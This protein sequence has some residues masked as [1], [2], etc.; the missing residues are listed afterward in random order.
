MK[1]FPAYILPVVFL[2]GVVSCGSKSR[3]KEDEGTQIEINYPWDNTSVSRADK[4]EED[5]WT[6]PGRWCENDTFSTNF[7]EVFNDSNYRQYAYAEHLGIKPIENLHDAYFT[8]RPIVRIADNSFYQ[9][10]SL[11]HSVPYLVPEASRLLDD[12]GRSFIDS[13]KNRGGNGY[14]VLVTSLLRTPSTVKRLMRVNINSK[15]SSCHKFATT[16]DLSYTRF[17]E[18]NPRKY[19]SPGTLKTILAKVLFDKRKEGKCLVKYEYK[20]NCFH[21]T[22]IK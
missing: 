3:E 18:N 8:S 13:V 15:D 4:E 12:I 6:G 14:K 7:G 10:D 19:M 21:I 5:N 1:K 20:T 16:F 11:T 9:V 2:A 17:A 22:A